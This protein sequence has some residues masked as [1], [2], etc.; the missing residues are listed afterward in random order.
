MGPLGLA[1]RLLS[2]LAGGDFTFASLSEGAESAP[3]QVTA[4]ELR[5]LYGMVKE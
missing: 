2:P 4:E 3:G 1:S 5:K